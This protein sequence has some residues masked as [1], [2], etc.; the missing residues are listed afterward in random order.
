MSESNESQKRLDFE[1]RTR[2]AAALDE[3]LPKSASNVSFYQRLGVTPVV[4][5]EAYDLN[6]E[7]LADAV[8]R[9]LEADYTISP[10][11]KSSYADYF[12]PGGCDCSCCYG[13]YGDTCHCLSNVCN[14]GG[15]RAAHGQK[16]LENK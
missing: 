3:A 1:L 14:C 4:D 9:E 13:N 8:I 11:G 5:I 15:D 12:C 6:L 10:K 16:P 2:I 7:L